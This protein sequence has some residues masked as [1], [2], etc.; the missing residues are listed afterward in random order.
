MKV[1]TDG[2]L[3]GAWAAGGT[4]DSRA[5]TILDIGTGTGV[6]ALMLAQ[7]FPE[8]EIDAVEIDQLAATTAAVNFQASPFASRMKCFPL[9]IEHYFMVYPEKQFDL[10]VS[11]PPFFVDSLKSD[12]KA[13]ETAR[14]AEPAF[15]EELCQLAA[16]HLH[17]DGRFCVILPLETADILLRFA[18]NYGLHPIE[19]VQVSSFPQSHPHRQLLSLGFNKPAE[20]QTSSLSIYEAEKVYHPVYRALLQNFLTIF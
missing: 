20:V 4:T 11:N 8:A 17:Q 7:R 3:L 13:K 12:N 1:N 2:V 19:I 18:Q 14:H 15:Y 9:A 16:L 5:T 6:I 10:I